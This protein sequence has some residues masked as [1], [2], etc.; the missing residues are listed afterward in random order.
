[1]S[2]YV[3]TDGD[4][5]GAECSTKRRFI[6]ASAYTPKAILGT[7]VVGAT[8]DANLQDASK[9]LADCPPGFV[10]GE[11]HEPSSTL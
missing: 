1:M 7:N 2:G 9:A 6:G 4:G 5:P 8:F 10:A 11:E 3:F